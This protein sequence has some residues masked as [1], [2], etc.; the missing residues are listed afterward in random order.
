MFCMID[1]TQPYF[2]ESFQHGDSGHDCGHEAEGIGC[3]QTGKND[4]A[5][6]SQDILDDTGRCQY[7]AA[8]NTFRE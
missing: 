2:R 1:W 6:E 8:A 7:A 5:D 4:I 3:K